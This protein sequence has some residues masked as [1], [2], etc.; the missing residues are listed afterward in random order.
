MGRHRAEGRVRAGRP[1][2][3]DLALHL[4]CCAAPPYSLRWDEQSSTAPGMRTM[5]GTQ[6][7]ASLTV[8]DVRRYSGC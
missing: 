5:L 3:E 2:A 8:Y 6:G 4:L 1:A 7:L